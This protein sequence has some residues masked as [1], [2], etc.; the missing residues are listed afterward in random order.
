MDSPSFNLVSGIQESVAREE[1][2]LADDLFSP[3]PLT[4][5]ESTPES[6]PNQE[7]VNLPP[8]EAEVDTETAPMTAQQRRKRKKMLQGRQNMKKRLQEEKQSKR[9]GPPVRPG[10]WKKYVEGATG[11]QTKAATSTAAVTRSAYI[12]R[13]V[14]DSSKKAHTLE[15]LV[16]PK[17]EYKYQL[18]KWDG[19]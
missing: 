4:T 16:G 8:D 13:N 5:P 14:P 15:E 11:V 18:R 9:E 10:V 1:L 17:S 7:P 2:Y 19:R 3:S 6:S 12:A